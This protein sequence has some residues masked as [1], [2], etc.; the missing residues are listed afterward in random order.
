ME[1]KFFQNPKPI[2]LIK[3]IIEVTLNSSNDI[4]LDFFSWSATTAHAVMALNAE[5]WGNRK[6]IMA[7]L[8]EL[9]DEKSEAYQAG[10]KTITEIGKE[11]IRRAGAKILEEHKGKEGIENLDT[12]FRV[13][14]VDS[15]N[16]KETYYQPS[17]IQQEEMGLFVD[18]IKEDRTGEDL[19]TQVI[20]DLGLTLDLPM[21][22]KKIWNQDVYFVWGNHLI[23]CFDENIS[24]EILEAIAKYQPLK[25]VFRDK[26]FETSQDLINL[27]NII[28]N[29]SPHTDIHVL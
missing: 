18:N 1:G 9:T 8:P 6:W 2:N 20:L 27:E 16:M 15:S 5:D 4:I 17:E 7:Q 11:R 3:Y 25:A 14:R 28:K 19:L 10:Y 26:S 13:Y 24:T 22:T 23:A 12:G 21:E 29:H